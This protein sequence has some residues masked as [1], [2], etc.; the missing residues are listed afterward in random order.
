[1]A[2][3]GR[4]DLKAEYFELGSGRNHSINELVTM[5]ESESVNIGP[6]TR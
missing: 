1:M 6:E 3:Q 5:Y 2:C 4:T